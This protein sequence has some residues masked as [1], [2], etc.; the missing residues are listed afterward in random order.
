M[1]KINY[2]FIKLFFN[3]IFLF[4]FSSLFVLALSQN[5]YANESY[6]T[7]NFDVNIDIS[8]DRIYTVNEDITVYYNDQSHGIFRY[9]PKN[10]TQ[11]RYIFNELDQREYTAF[12]RNPLVD[13]HPYVFSKNSSDIYYFQIGDPKVKVDGLHTYN[14]SYDYLLSDDGIELFDDVYI[15]II[16]HEW[17][18]TIENAQI[19]VHLPKPFNT[20][21]VELISGRKN[22]VNTNKAQYTVEG[23]TIKISLIEPLGM[24][25]GVS[26]RVL[27]P[28]GYFTQRA[29]SITTWEYVVILTSLF[30]VFL[31]YIL[32]VKFAR[33]RK[34]PEPISYYPPNDMNPAEISYL[35][36]N[37]ISLQDFSSMLLYFANKDLISLDIDDKKNTYITK[38]KDLPENSKKHEKVFFDGLFE[39]GNTLCINEIPKEYYALLNLGIKALKEQYKEIKA[40]VYHKGRVLLLFVFLS[41]SMIP[42]LLLNF[43]DYTVYEDAFIFTFLSFFA[44]FFLFLLKLRGKK[45]RSKKKKIIEKI[46]LTFFLLLFTGI[47]F[48]IATTNYATFIT[49][50]FA[51]FSSFTI[52]YLAPAKDKPTAF[53][54]KI[55][56]EI[57]GFKKFIEVSEIEKLNLLVEENPSYCYDIL[58]YAYIFHLSSTWLDKLQLVKIPLHISDNDRFN[59]YDHQG[60]RDIGR[61][62][63]SL[64]T[65]AGIEGLI[66]HTQREAAA[67]ARNS[68]NNGGGSGGSGGSSGGTSGGGAGGGGGGNW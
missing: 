36:N 29:F 19:S 40:K 51:I 31:I 61:V 17:A 57:L 45:S 9:I 58:P 32:Y 44:P 56:G 1:Q 23:N 53:G 10:G 14:I 48:F 42:Y 59:T 52:L 28:Q 20:N 24:Y 8:E 4:F 64:A 5:L 25:E 49:P 22:S 30:L 34:F 33:I 65:E 12:I 55:L 39:H 46:V 37:R 7:K 3:S 26:L 66:A 50:F 63:A 35:I 38:L 54:E 68:T 67:A 11:A 13:D 15:N 18:S 16:P 6:L 60:F 47:P 43:G 2:T 62:T 41:M 27:L 21:E